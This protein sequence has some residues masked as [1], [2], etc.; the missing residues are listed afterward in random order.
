MLPAIL[1]A[2]RNL[3]IG[4]NTYLQAAAATVYTYPVQISRARVSDRFSMNETAAAARAAFPE[5]RSFA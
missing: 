5:R 1:G 3:I 4:A 2:A